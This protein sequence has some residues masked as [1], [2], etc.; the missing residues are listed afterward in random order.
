M[1]ER[2]KLHLMLRYNCG[3][4]KNFGMSSNGRTTDFGSVYFGSNPSVPAYVFDRLTVRKSC[5][6]S[7]SRTTDF[8]SDYEFCIA[9][10]A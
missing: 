1:V 3:T 6:S 7:K 2:L 9:K 8:G 10:F 5:F 4:Q